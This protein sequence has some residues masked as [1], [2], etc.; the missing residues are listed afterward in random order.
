MK[1]TREQL[2]EI[3]R[4]ELLKEVKIRTKSGH[5]IELSAVGSKLKISGLGQGY[6]EVNG[7][8]DLKQFVN[9]L[10]KNMGIV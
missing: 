3:I 8:H 4:E 9:I 2:K 7:H 5:T 10:S 6:I 1:I